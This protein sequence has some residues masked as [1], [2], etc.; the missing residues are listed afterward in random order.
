MNSFRKLIFLSLSLALLVPFACK[1]ED[2]ER[3]FFS[4]LGP[5]DK[6][7]AIVDKASQALN[8]IGRDTVIHS[9]NGVSAAANNLVKKGVILHFGSNKIVPQI[10]FCAAGILASACGLGVL[11]YTA[12]QKDQQNTKKKYLAGAGML[13]LGIAALA[14]SCLFSWKN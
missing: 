6:T 8:Y 12:L 10:G 14:T 2:I 13:G 3:D 11:T 5:L 4:F 1:A 9:L 7:D